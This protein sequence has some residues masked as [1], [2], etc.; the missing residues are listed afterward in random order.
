MDTIY[1][2][3]KGRGSKYN[4]SS[5]TSIIRFIVNNIKQAIGKYSNFNTEYAN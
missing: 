5:Y 3:D 4:G 1:F 2:F